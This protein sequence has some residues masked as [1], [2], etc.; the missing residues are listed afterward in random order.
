MYIY[1][2]VKGEEEAVS[3]LRRMCVLQADEPLHWCES[4]AHTGNGRTGEI[5]VERIYEMAPTDDCYREYVI[6]YM[7]SHNPKPGQRHHGMISELRQWAYED[8][9]TG[10][11]A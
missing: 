7:V 4:F 11:V 5:L 9:R 10:K 1:K 8:I 6:M 3:L 2:V